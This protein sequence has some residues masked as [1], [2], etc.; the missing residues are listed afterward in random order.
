VRT[1]KIKI[2]STNFGRQRCAG[3]FNFGVKGLMMPSHNGDD[4]DDDDD[5]EDDHYF[6]K[7]PNIYIP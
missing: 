3:G 5:S 1:L 4:E 2:P 6:H 7:L